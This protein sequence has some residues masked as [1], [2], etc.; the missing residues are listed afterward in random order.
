MS[1]NG[2]CVLYA[3]QNAIRNDLILLIS[4]LFTLW[5]CCLFIEE[6]FWLLYFCD[7]IFCTIGY[8]Y[9][10]GL[11]DLMFLRKLILFVVLCVS[12]FIEFYYLFLFPDFE[13]LNDMLVAVSLVLIIYCW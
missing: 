6:S 2:V 1:W 4:F 11:I 3:V 10:E 12:G 8:L 9:R 7:L 13:G 5:H